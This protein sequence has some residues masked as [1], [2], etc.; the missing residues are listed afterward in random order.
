MK[1][2]NVNQFV[3]STF[4]NDTWGFLGFILQYVAMLYRFYPSVIGQDSEP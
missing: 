3:L 2:Q 1:H 4:K